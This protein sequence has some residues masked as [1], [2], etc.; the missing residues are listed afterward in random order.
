VAFVIAMAIG[1]IA[2]LSGAALADA[3]TW[4]AASLVALGLV[5]VLDRKVLSRRPASAAAVAVAF[6]MA[7]GCAHGNAHGLE[8][9]STAGPVSF[10]S[11][12]LAGTSLLH[13]AGMAVGHLSE[14]W[15]VVAGPVRIAGL[16][17]AAVGCGML[18]R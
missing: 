2:G 1:G 17:A 6:V 10:A 3:E 18:I 16:F 15:P 7:F 13:L 12:F 9:P 8:I 5:V 11:G 4:I 14:R